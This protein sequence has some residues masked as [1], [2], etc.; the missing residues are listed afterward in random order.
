MAHVSP[1]NLQTA[2]QISS[3]K[4][5]RPPEFL[6]K[7]PHVFFTN[8]TFVET[9]VQSNAININTAKHLGTT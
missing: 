3:L 7:K 9:P 2:L 5:V 8:E 4:F 1:A 6:W